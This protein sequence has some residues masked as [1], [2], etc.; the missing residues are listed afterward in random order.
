MDRLPN[1]VTR[2]LTVYHPGTWHRVSQLNHRHRR[3]ASQTL[4]SVR[5]YPVMKKEIFKGSR[6]S[7]VVFRAHKVYSVSE[8]PDDARLCEWNGDENL[9]P[10]TVYDIYRKRGVSKIECIERAMNVFDAVYDAQTK[11][12]SIEGFIRGTGSPEELALSEAFII[13][14]TQDRILNMT[15][16][17]ISK[18]NLT[19]EII[20]GH[21]A[22]RLKFMQ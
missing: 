22:A 13:W 6:K 19:P 4:E 17:G 3:L 18:D 7:I 15:I 12:A 16:K 14:I 8:I 21:V 11:S 2:Q 10:C 20:R 5:R 1:D 9:H